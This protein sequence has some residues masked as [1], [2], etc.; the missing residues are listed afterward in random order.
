M[1][2]FD[3]IKELISGIERDAK[4][5]AEAEM[6]V[7]DISL[8]YIEVKSWL[9][10]RSK[11][12]RDDVEGY[13]LSV[14]KSMKVISVK[15]DEDVRALDGAKIEDKLEKRMERAVINNRKALVS[16]LNM[17]NHGL[18]FS[19]DVFG[20]YDLF[21]QIKGDMAHL[22]EDTSKNFYFVGNGFSF[23]SEKIKKN[24]F[25]FGKKIDEAI[26][27]LEPLK[28]KIGV[29]SDAHDIIEDLDSR[30]IKKKE[31]E[32][33]I[34]SEQKK[35]KKCSASKVVLEKKIKSIDKGSDIKDLQRLSLDHSKIIKDRS[36][37]EGSIVQVVSPIGR[38]LKKYSRVAQLSSKKEEQILRLY[39]EDPV[40]AVE[41]DVGLKLFKRV[42]SELELHLGRGSI[43]LKDKIRVKTISAISR[44]K[45]DDEL[46]ELRKQLEE[47]KKDEAA[48]KRKIDSDV[49]IQNKR[50]LENGC[51]KLSEDIRL[52]LADVSA[53]E[54]KLDAHMNEVESQ[55][56][57]LEKK[58]NAFGNCAVSISY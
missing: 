40:A 55:V 25:E 17:F 26:V 56:R 8:D 50:V 3:K 14:L 23:K 43:A 44:L 36:Y 15:L 22:M 35:L 37:V 45:A 24:L 9:D 34:A 41:M 11:P 29:V 16:K 13:T 58:L 38:V 18:V 31:L 30:F 39:T 7:E 20:S 5:R 46:S 49:T 12:I 1:G 33:D 27:Y 4:T 42:L 57:A 54:K 47:L 52:L 53:K 32:D 19:T 51:A 21:N 10:S 2:F 28:K 48:I 6:P